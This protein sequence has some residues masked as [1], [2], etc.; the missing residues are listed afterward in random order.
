MKISNNIK[1]EDWQAFVRNHPKG[2]VF[3]SPGM[4][5]FFRSVKKFDPVVLGVEDENDQLFGLLTGIYVY[6]KTGLFKLLSSRFVIYGGP[7][8]S[9]TEEQKR[10]ALN[11]LLGDLVKKTKHKA[12]FIQLRNYF[13][14][15]EYLPVFEGHGFRLLDRLNFIV[16]LPVSGL[17]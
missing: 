14:W 9:G 2:T 12:L 16:R 7:L 1:T 6:E 11:L 8:I 5:D 4:Y 17:R 3:Q 13:S 10:D 15:E